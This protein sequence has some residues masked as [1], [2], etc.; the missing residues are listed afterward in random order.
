MD[1]SKLEELLT[2]VQEGETSPQAAAEK[3]RLLPF[4]DL[5]VAK[6]DHH[7]ALRTGMP[8]VILCECKTSEQVAKQFAHMEAF[9][10]AVLATLAVLLHPPSRHSSL[11]LTV[12]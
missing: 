6:I 2:A 1:R 3:L 11:P 9:H 7:L 8:E 4:E 10:G 5:G 12:H